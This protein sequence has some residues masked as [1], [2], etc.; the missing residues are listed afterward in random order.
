MDM[1]LCG[2]TRNVQDFL[3]APKEWEGLWEGLMHRSLQLSGP[4]KGDLYREWKS[5]SSNR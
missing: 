4:P 3:E 1:G 5:T 2:N